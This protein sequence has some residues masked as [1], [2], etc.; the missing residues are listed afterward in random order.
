MAW[1]LNNKQQIKLSLSIYVLII[2]ISVISNYQSCDDFFPRN[3]LS[4]LDLIYFGDMPSFS[5]IGYASFGAIICLVLGFSPEILLVMPIS[6]IP[7]SVIG[8][9]ILYRLSK[10]TL[11]STILV[12]CLYCISYSPSNVLYWIH[13]VGN[14]LYLT[15]FLLLIIWFDNK[16]KNK[17]YDLVTFLCISILLISLNYV[18]Y[19]ITAIAVLNIFSLTVIVLFLWMRDKYY[20][21]HKKYVISNSRIIVLSIISCALIMSLNSFYYS[22]INFGDSMGEVGVSSLDKYLIFASKLIGYND[23]T[24]TSPLTPYY[25]SDVTGIPFIGA[26]RYIIIVLAILIYGYW[27]LKIFLGKQG[28]I[29]P[30]DIILS[31]VLLG[32]IVY[33]LIRILVVGSSHSIFLITIPGVLIL[34]RMTAI[35]YKPKLGKIGLLF[36][37]IFILLML[38]QV[39]S[40]SLSKID[41]PKNL[42]SYKQISEFGA[43]AYLYSTKDMSSD[44]FTY[45]SICLSS[46]VD[47]N[48]ILSE[49]ISS[50][51]SSFVN[52]D[53]ILS[54]FDSNVPPSKRNIIINWHLKQISASTKDWVTLNPWKKYEDEIEYNPN[55][56]IVCSSGF[57]VCLSSLT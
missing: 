1:N 56:N 38:V 32:Y 40:V 33:I 6:I 53:E 48:P 26:L 23:F 37:I 17:S 54:I 11:L 7:L 19:D 52:N 28:I 20:D 57:I 12:G 29:H 44:V 16:H 35:K 42:E 9:V 45:A 43:W 50:K 22:F 27:L 8:F 13:T 2:T 55:Y 39:S 34:A 24:S 3:I 46:V 41:E 4:F 10:N 14:I 5:M 30:I 15:I 18:S 31:S 21:L 51:Y 36:V 25:L 49:S 47:K